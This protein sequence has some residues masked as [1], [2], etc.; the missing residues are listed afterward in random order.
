MC[1]SRSGAPVRDFVA[2]LCRMPRRIQFHY[3]PAHTSRQNMPGIGMGILERQSLAR[4]AA[5]QVTLIAEVAAW[6][7]RCNAAQC[8][9]ERTFTPKRRG[10]EA[11][12]TLCLAS[13][14]SSYRIS[15]HSRAAAVEPQH[16]LWIRCRT[17]PLSIINVPTA[18]GVSKRQLLCHGRGTCRRATL[19]SHRAP[20]FPG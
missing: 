7:R 11:V 12:S 13:T 15:P 5:D 1:R 20:H 19:P 3:A 10:S 16:G 8:G 6:Q 17:D 4:R 9:I 14:V 2:F 18:T